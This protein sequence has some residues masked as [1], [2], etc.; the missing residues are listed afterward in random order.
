MFGTRCSAQVVVWLAGLWLAAGGVRAGEVERRL[1]A[2]DLEAR[3]GQLFM[4]SLPDGELDAAERAWL[5]RV[6]PGGVLVFRRNAGG[7]ARLARWSNA[8]QAAARPGPGLLLA[9]DL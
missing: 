4:V 8:L 3:V 1:A 9:V 2:M 6:R 5:R 7:P